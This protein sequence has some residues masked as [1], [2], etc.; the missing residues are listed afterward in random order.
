M[1]LM[2]RWFSLL[3]IAQVF[4][5]NMC[6]SRGTGGNDVSPIS[7]NSFEM[8]ATSASLFPFSMEM[9]TALPEI[10]FLD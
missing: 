9:Q 4:L 6:K 10:S 3:L 7:I 2:R 5:N 1:L 8:K